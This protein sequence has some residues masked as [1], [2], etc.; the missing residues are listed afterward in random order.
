[1]LSQ[2]NEL[3]PSFGN[4]LSGLVGG[5]WE[6]GRWWREVPAMA[7]SLDWNLHCV[8]TSVVPFLILKGV[9]GLGSQT[10]LVFSWNLWSSLDL[11]L[12]FFGF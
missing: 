7:K 10:F 4:E 11:V 2:E 1:L 8:Q 12:R 9:F 6:V 5:K 3:P